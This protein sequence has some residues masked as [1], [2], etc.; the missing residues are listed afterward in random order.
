MAA[1]RAGQRVVRVA[2]AGAVGGVRRSAAA[3]AAAA[4]GVGAGVG[5]ERIVAELQRS[6][7][8][9]AAVRVLEEQGYER[10][11]VSHITQRARVSRRTFYELFP[12]REQCVAA[13]L[14]DA[15]GQVRGEL[16]RAGLAGLSWRERVRGGLWAILCFLEREPALGRVLVVHALRGSGE[17]LV[18]REE[19]VAEL[20]AAVDAGRVDGVGAAGCTS[21]TAEGVV[22][23]GLAILYGR[24][25]VGG[26]GC[27]R[28]T[29]LLGELMAM[30]VL[31][32]LGSGVAR[33]EQA[34][35][36]P[37]VLMA[38]G[39]SEAGS[40]AATVV[41][42]LE[43][44]SMRLTYRTVR[45]LEGLARRPGASNREVADAA[46]ILDQGQVSKLLSRLEGLGL[47]CN[48]SAGAARGE[49]NR[50]RL[51]RRGELVTGSF[52]SHIDMPGRRSA[53]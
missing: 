38:E 6:R 18:A 50:W 8:L 29:E 10:S 7:L 33:R 26:S 19:I 43:G 27:P 49:R 40:V 39:G 11:T 41:D 14:R 21:L 15:A 2:S 42:P 3:A 4:G 16:E 23:A 37:R 13:V 36:L 24:L 53:A 47:L 22:G 25:V 1:S 5:R 51:T 35:A 52:A 28:L 46:G 9:V 48:E 44:L 12:N 20:V 31:P 45:V 30:V 32:Y 17:V 34:R